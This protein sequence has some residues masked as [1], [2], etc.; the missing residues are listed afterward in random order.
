LLPASPTF[1]WIF[2]SGNRKPLEVKTAVDPRGNFDV[3]SSAANYHAWWSDPWCIS[4]WEFC[5]TSMIVVGTRQWA[6][7]AVYLRK[8]VLDVDAELFADQV[9]IW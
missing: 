1:T 9:V 8:S 2:P 7:P 6:S 4:F 3:L 5:R